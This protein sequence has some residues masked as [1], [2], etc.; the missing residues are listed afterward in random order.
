MNGRLHTRGGLSSCPPPALFLPS[1][2]CDLDSNH[3]PRLKRLSL[4]LCALSY[5]QSYCVAFSLHRAV[6]ALLLLSLTSESMRGL[7]NPNE[8]PVACPNTGFFPIHVAVANGLT[9]MF[10]FLQEL[11]ALSECREQRA[12]PEGLSLRAAWGP[13]GRLTPLQLACYLGDHRM[14]QHI[15]KRRAQ[16]NWMWGPVTEYRVHLEGVDSLGEGDN[17]VMNLVARSDARDETK[18]MLAQE[19]LL[20]FIHDLFQDKWNHFG[21]TVFI[22]MTLFD[23]L[24]VGT[25]AA[26]AISQKMLPR[27]SI[28][29]DASEWRWE[30]I[31]PMVCLISMGPTMIAD[32]FC[33]LQYYR[34][35]R[36]S[37]IMWKWLKTYSVH[38]KWLALCLTIGSC[39]FLITLPDCSRGECKQT[40]DRYQ[41]LAPV[42]AFLA[43][44]LLL[45]VQRFAQALVAPSQNLGTLYIITFKMLFSDVTRFMIIFAIF[46]LNYGLAMYLTVPP[47]VIDVT[48]DNSEGKWTLI[49]MFQDLVKLGLLGVELP[50]DFRVQL[51]DTQGAYDK[52]NEGYLGTWGWWNLGI[53]LGMYVFYTLMSIILLL[54]LLIA[55]MG[56]TYETTME[57]SE[58][59]WRVSF[60]RRILLYETLAAAYNGVRSKSKQFE[61]WAGTK[62]PDGRYYHVFRNVTANSEG[63]GTGGIVPLFNQQEETR[64]LPMTSHAT[65]SGQ[66]P[67]E[68]SRSTS[69]DPGKRAPSPPPSS[70]VKKGGLA[71]LAVP[72][73][74]AAPAM[75]PDPKASEGAGTQ[76][77]Y[78]TPRE[79]WRRTSELLSR[80][81]GL[82]DLSG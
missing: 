81:S 50:M 68:S 2:S 43:I 40:Y 56:Q 52:F 76:E 27:Y 37:K 67:R 77:E 58:I 19:F 38:T 74:A 82:A 29:T 15:L 66:T 24:Y 5:V 13:V 20:G 6:A 61:L 34:S 30:R 23:L 54:N 59:E 11:P 31:G 33:A 75:L 26:L 10:D 39:V 57:V 28:E 45:A 64:A 41:M 7:T 51:S 44:P 4:P 22:W 48:D 80:V 78:L 79:E 14:F 35:V 70:L 32:T 16:V 18:Q 72:P 55:M 65:A 3:D 12:S 69:P 36:S 53:F 46:L 62:Y 21:R 42:W 8:S 73:L 9:Q 60:A 25:L 63:A 49:A 71:P 1:S 47:Y 17:D